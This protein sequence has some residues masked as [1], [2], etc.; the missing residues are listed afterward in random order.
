MILSSWEERSQRKTPAECTGSQ[1]LGLGSISIANALSTLLMRRIYVH[2]IVTLQDRQLLGNFNR[3]S[4]LSSY[5]QVLNL[6]G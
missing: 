4:L 5:C 2:A 3:N 6:S 1:P